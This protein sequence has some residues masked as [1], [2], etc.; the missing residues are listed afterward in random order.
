M[1][2]EQLIITASQVEEED[3]MEFLP[4]FF[5]ESLMLK[6]E[7]LVYNWM[8]RLSEDYQGG[9]WQFYHLSNGGFYMAPDLDRKLVLCVPGNW[10]QRELSADAAGIVATL[11]VLCQLANATEE[12][13]LIDLYYKLKAYL[14]FHP[15]G[16]LIAQAI[17]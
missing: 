7:G 3:R 17:D 5:G 2:N 1:N 9:L 6:G 10:F 16:G 8:R 15:E 4:A 14:D 13:R 11:F 12:D